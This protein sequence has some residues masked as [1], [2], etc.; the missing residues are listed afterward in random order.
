M[1]TLIR[2]WSLQ[3]EFKI[4]KTSFMRKSDRELMEPMMK[5]KL[6]ERSSS[7][8]ISMAMVLLNGPNSRRLLRLLAAYSRIKNLK[9][10]SRNMMLITMES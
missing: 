3:R 2:L 8:L 9:L 7:I 5:A 6:L 4:L 1:T 10:Y